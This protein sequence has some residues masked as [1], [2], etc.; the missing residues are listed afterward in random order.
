[1]INAF[2]GN[3]ARVLAIESYPSVQRISGKAAYPCREIRVAFTGKR[4]FATS[5]L[6]LARIMSNGVRACFNGDRFDLVISAERNFM[7]VL[8]AFMISRLIR[9]PLVVVIHHAVR[10]DYV[11]RRELPSQVRTKGLVNGLFLSWGREIHRLICRRAELVVAVSE[12]TKREFCTTYGI[13]PERVVVTGNGSRVRPDPAAGASVRTVDVAYL[14]RFAASKGSFLLPGIWKMVVEKRLGSRLVIAGGRGSELSQMRDLVTEMRLQESVDVLGYLSDDEASALLATT[15]V[16]VL[17]STREGF[18]IATAD[19]MSAGCVCVVSDL[20]ALRGVFGDAATYVPVGDVSK[21]AEAILSALRNE[22]KRKE[23]SAR[24]IDYASH[25][26]WD[27]IAKEE[28]GL[29]AT[30]TARY[31]RV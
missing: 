9:R 22:A 29:Y 24:S 7:N 28:L 30:L 19:A 25:F 2:Q 11:D 26:S 6:N 21:F 15:K 1:M 10:D 23:L 27:A 12:A 4:R 17:P 8:P 18:S 20:P 16:F 13:L 5:M 14:G 31:K 3:G